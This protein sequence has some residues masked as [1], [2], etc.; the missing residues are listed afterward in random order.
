MN[1]QELFNG[2]VMALP[3]ER[4]DDDFERY[5]NNVLES[6]LDAVRSLDLHCHLCKGIRMA[7]GEVAQLSQWICSAVRQYLGGRPA[8]AYEEVLKAIK[9]VYVRLQTL[10]SKE[11]GPDQI[12]HL[13]RMVNT[14]G[15]AVGKERLFHPPFELRHKVAQHRY[16]IPGFPCLYLGGSLE[17]CKQELRIAHSDLPNVAVSEFAV[18]TKIKVLNFAHRPSA[19]AQ[20][21]VG[22]AKSERDADPRLEEFLINYAT[23]WPLIA[24]CS[25][26]VMHDGEPFVYEYIV[27]QMVLQWAMSNSECDGIRF[28]STRFTPGPEAIKATANYVFPAVPGPHVRTGFSQSLKHAFELT[29]PVLWGPLKTFDLRKEALGKEG[30][31]KDLP[32]APLP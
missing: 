7:E 19:L 10:V 25:I 16:G 21:A 12:G 17:L 32:K 26:K 4:D 9:F 24:A 28:F 1:V 20:I 14:N 13:Y 30:E 6:Y 22:R 11:V 27:P 18:R 3:R 23:C 15:I 2:E 5:L 31:L 8:A 29:T